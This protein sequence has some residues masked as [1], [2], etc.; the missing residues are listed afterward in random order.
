MPG[1]CGRF[2]EEL[3]LVERMRAIG[4]IVVEK[5]PTILC[6]QAWLWKDQFDAAPT[7]LYMS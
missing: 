1:V 7:Q 4:D 3:A 6:F 2:N 5:G